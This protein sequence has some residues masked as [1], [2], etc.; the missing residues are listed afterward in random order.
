MKIA[1]PMN[2]FDTLL[3]FSHSI[4]HRWRC[5]HMKIWDIKWKFVFWKFSYM[6]LFGRISKSGDN[7][8]LWCSPSCFN[9]LCS[10]FYRLVWFGLSILWTGTFKYT[11][12]VGVGHMP[13]CHPQYAEPKL[14]KSVKVRAETIKTW[15][16][17]LY[18]TIMTTFGNPTK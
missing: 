1:P 5:F 12:K 11:L 6:T 4:V 18:W 3:I 16:G 2:T 10:V 15:W 7:G 9:S 8:Q 14:N 17:T 13:S